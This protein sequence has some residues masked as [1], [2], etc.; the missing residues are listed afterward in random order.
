MDML[1]YRIQKKVNQICDG[2]ERRGEAVCAANVLK[3][4]PLSAT[5]SAVG[6]CIAHWE[7]QHN[8]RFY[9][10]L[11]QILPLLSCF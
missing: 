7:K 8:N 4:L 3:Y 5:V 2:L 11:A 10:Y 6:T 9:D 1:T